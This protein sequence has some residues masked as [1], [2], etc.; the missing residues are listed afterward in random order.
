MMINHPPYYSPNKNIINKI[1]KHGLGS[2][3]QQN[4]KLS[5]INWYPYNHVYPKINKP[6]MN[7]RVPNP[8]II[9]ICMYQKIDQ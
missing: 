7:C 8:S 9:Y 3:N 1:Y 4:Y 6:Y 5:I 2:Y